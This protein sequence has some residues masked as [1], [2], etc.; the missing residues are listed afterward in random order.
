MKICTASSLP[1]INFT[2][3]MYVHITFLVASYKASNFM[4]WAIMSRY[5]T[6]SE[7][8]YM[9]KHCAITILPRLMC[10]C[11]EIFTYSYNV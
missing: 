7:L 9:I 6:D 2:E 5:K 4:E 8:P 3:L 10:A 11:T 1:Y